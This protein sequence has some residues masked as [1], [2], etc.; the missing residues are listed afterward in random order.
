MEPFQTAPTGAVCSGS[1]LFV[2]KKRLQRHFSRCQKQ[3]TLVEI[4]ALRVKITQPAKSEF[5]T[6]FAIK[7]KF[8]QSDE[9]SYLGSHCSVGNINLII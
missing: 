8:C 1:S 3:T 6:I 5:V 2:K 7:Y 4:G 9:Q